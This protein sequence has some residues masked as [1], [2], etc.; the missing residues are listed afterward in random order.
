VG[1]FAAAAG[2]DDGNYQVMDVVER[3]DV[4]PHPMLQDA[5]HRYRLW[6]GPLCDCS[7]LITAVTIPYN[8]FL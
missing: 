2:D 5:V 1:I 3:T 7:V 4:G 8:S 6:A